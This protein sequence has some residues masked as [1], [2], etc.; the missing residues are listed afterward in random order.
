MAAGEIV[1]CTVGPPGSAQQCPEPPVVQVTSNGMVL[2]YCVAHLWLVDRF[3]YDVTLI[4]GQSSGC[5]GCDCPY[6]DCVA[7]EVECCDLCTH[8]VP[9]AGGSERDTDG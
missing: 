2:R 5:I 3:D 8:P 1:R 9:D 7:G 6:L 4:G